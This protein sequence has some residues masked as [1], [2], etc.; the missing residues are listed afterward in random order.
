MELEKGEVGLRDEQVLVVALVADD[1]AADAV[2]RQVVRERRHGPVGGSEAVAVRPMSS[3]GDRPALRPAL[4]HEGRERRPR[5][6]DRVEVERRGA[7][8]RRAERVALLLVERGEVEGDVVVDELGEV[9]VAGGD[10]GVVAVLRGRVV[11]DHRLRQLEER[12]VAGVERRQHREHPP[13]LAGVAVAA[14]RLQ[15]L[16]RHLAGGA[17][18][19]GAG[20]GGGRQVVHRARGSLSAVNE[21]CRKR[22]DATAWRA[23]VPVSADGA[24]AGR[25]G[26]RPGF[27]LAARAW[28]LTQALGRA[29]RP[30]R[31]LPSRR[32]MV[33][34]E[35]RRPGGPASRP[36]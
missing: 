24:C 25:W 19:L 10:I 8:V 17:A 15:R 31:D 23:P 35:V 29:T 4:V 9:G 1:G 11:V 3:F 30:G 27:P 13:E 34:S 32:S 7:E 22:A 14:E 16:E 26:R 2:A 33:R 18:V 6:V 21:A 20:G 36:P 12:V 28:R 5:P